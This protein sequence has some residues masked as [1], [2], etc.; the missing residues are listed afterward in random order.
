MSDPTPVSFSD[1]GR[2]LTHERLL[3][4][5]EDMLDT[6]HG[7]QVPLDV[8]APSFG[9]GAMNGWD[10]ATSEFFRRVSAALAEA[11]LAGWQPMATA[12]RDGKHCILSVPTG[13]FFYTVQGAFQ[14][15]Q[16]NAVHADNVQP[17]AW[18]PNVLLPD[19]LAPHKSEASS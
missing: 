1:H 11:P 2:G 7:R 3:E 12:P 8:D 14:D 4:I 15:G 9:R 13:P 10:A 16:W 17:V 5:C 6:H 19:H 18:M